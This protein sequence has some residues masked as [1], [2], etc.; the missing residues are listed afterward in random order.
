MGTL[1]VGLLDVKRKV[2]RRIC[3][4]DYVMAD[5]YVG[6]AKQERLGERMRELGI[7]ESELIE[8]FV[9]GSGPGGQKINKTSSCVYLRH[10]ARGIEVKC[11]KSRSRHLN[12]YLARVELC[13]R[14][15]EAVLGERSRRQQEIEKIRRRKRRRTYKQKQRMLE[16]KRKNAKK[17]RL[18]GP[19]SR[20]DD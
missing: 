12:R 4:K 14:V 5:A 8:K 19:V 18:R 9:L 16:Q 7:E 1:S 15:E 20:E 3:G 10:P 11:Q 13:E 17:K 2:D 6:K